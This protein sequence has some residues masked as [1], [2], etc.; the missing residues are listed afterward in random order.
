M[1]F[2]DSLNFPNLQEG[3]GSVLGASLTVEDILQAMK[4]MNSEK[5][6]GPDGLPID[7]Y[8]KFE[9]KIRTPLFEMFLESLQNV[10]LSLLF[11]PNQVKVTISLKI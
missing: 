9:S 3:E 4:C 5:A 11:S 7:I 8:N 1:A 10:I 2:L 6:V